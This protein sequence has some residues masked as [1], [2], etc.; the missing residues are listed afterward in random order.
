MCEV[1]RWF[2]SVLCEVDDFQMCKARSDL[3]LHHD[4]RPIVQIH[5]RKPWYAKSGRCCNPSTTKPLTG[6]SDNYGKRPRAEQKLARGSDAKTC[7]LA[8]GHVSSKSRREFHHRLEESLQ[9]TTGKPWARIVA[10]PVTQGRDTQGPPML[11][12]QRKGNQLFSCESIHPI[13]G[14]TPLKRVTL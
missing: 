5:E 13:V 3:L 2:F 10:N 12:F 14:S 6:Y 9:S 1:R 11:S 4:R 7:D 8:H